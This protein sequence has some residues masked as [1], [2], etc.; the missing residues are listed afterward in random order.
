MFANSLT[1]TC[2]VCRVD[3]KGGKVGVQKGSDFKGFVAFWCDLTAV[4]IM[5]NSFKLRLWEHIEWHS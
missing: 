2:G 1:I 3:V 4:S 5:S